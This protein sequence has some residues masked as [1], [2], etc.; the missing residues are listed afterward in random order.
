MGKWVVSEIVKESDVTKRGKLIEHF[1]AIAH[2][3]RELNNF[4]SMMGILILYPLSQFQGIFAGL[5]SSS[6]SR[7]KKTWELVPQDEVSRF[8]QECNILFS[9]NYKL[10]R[11]A[12]KQSV[13]PSVCFCSYLFDILASIFRNLS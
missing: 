5:T 10:L 4:N 8:E 12:V 7:L 9:K 2:R 13:P 11:D 3:C 1:L 6:I